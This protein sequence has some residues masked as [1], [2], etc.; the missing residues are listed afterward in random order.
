[1]PSYLSSSFRK[2]P[3]KSDTNLHYFSERKAQAVIFMKIAPAVN[4]LAIKP[5]LKLA[6]VEQYIAHTLEIGYETRL[7]ESLKGTRIRKV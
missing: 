4:F 6:S 1:M 7:P 2:G 3:S 5:K